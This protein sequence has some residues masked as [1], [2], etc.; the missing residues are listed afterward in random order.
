MSS[1][2]A[3]YEAADRLGRARADV[4]GLRRT[5]DDLLSP[6]PPGAPP[7]PSNLA[8]IEMHIEIY[9]R[10]LRAALDEHD[11]AEREMDAVL[12]RL[13]TTRE[14]QGLADQ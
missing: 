3:A 11:R 2:Q 5:L 9:E 7:R 6:P 13:D 1:F 12:N 4:N 8:P 10:H 14:R